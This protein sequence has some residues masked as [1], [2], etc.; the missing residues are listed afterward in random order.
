MTSYQ[1][2]VQMT[3]GWG[4]GCQEKSLSRDCHWGQGKNRKQIWGFPTC[5]LLLLLCGWKILQCMQIT[6]CLWDQR[7]CS[8]TPAATPVCKETKSCISAWQQLMDCSCPNKHWIQQDL[9]NLTVEKKRVFL[10]I[11]E[12]AGSLAQGSQF[13]KRAGNCWPMERCCSAGTRD[14]LRYLEPVCC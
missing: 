10:L 12:T 11:P 8:S 7:P 6:S 3:A 14:R 9:R 2:Q 13:V 5:L 4:T 1:G